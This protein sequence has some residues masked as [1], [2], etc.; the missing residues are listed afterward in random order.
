MNFDHMPEL[1]WQ[2]GYPLTILL[3]LATSLT[4]YRIFKKRRWL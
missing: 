1:H 2:I 3:M 4:L